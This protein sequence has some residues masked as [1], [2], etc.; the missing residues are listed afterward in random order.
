MATTSIIHA[1]IIDAARFTSQPTPP[2]HY[3]HPLTYQLSSI[4]L[5]RHFSQPSPD[6]VYTHNGVPM[7]PAQAPSKWAKNSSP[8][9][10]EKS[11][12]L[13]KLL[14][15]VQGFYSV[16]FVTSAGKLVPHDHGQPFNTGCSHWPNSAAGTGPTFCDYLTFKKRFSSAARFTYCYFCGSPQDRS[17]SHKEAPQCYRVAGFGKVCPWADFPHMVVF[18]VWH[19]KDI[20]KEMIANFQ[21]EEAMP[22]KEFVEWCV[23]EHR[24]EGEYTKMLEVFFWYCEKYYP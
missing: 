4:S 5:V 21:L 24:N 20:R 17:G 23:K 6:I 13:N 19:T 9:R 14:N 3:S 8:S 1:P 22:Y 10:M 16:L 2:S 12:L 15:I 18:F 7:P 11:H